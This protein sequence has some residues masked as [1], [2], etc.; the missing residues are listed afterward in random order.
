MAE[1]SLAISASEAGTEWPHSVAPTEVVD[2]EDGSSK[3]G[4]QRSSS[5]E[6]HESIAVT[7]RK[8]LE[9]RGV[10]NQEGMNVIFH[11]LCAEGSGT[12]VRLSLGSHGGILI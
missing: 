5:T 8:F 2:L 10:A 9:L 3:G 12:G 4:E 11:E 7:V 1:S 6:K